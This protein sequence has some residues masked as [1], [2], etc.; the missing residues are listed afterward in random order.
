MLK[1]EWKKQA[2]VVSRVDQDS[3]KRD[4]TGK[5]QRSYLFEKHLR[6]KAIDYECEMLLVNLEKEFMAYAKEMRGKST[7]PGGVPS[8]RDEGRGK[9]P[10]PD[11]T[12]DAP[13]IPKLT[14]G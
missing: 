4:P 2:E 11:R 7:V 9:R 5:E 8:R 3:F 13:A 12:L 1:K 6:N 14:R 10:E